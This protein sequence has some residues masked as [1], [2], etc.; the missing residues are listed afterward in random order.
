[1]KSNGNG[2]ARILVPEICDRLQ[3]GRRAVYGLLE[4]KII[5]S[6]RV[7]VRWVISRRAYEEWERSFGKHNAIAL[8]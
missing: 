1:M 3:L 7:G 6:I 5:P 8:Q 2:S 4:A